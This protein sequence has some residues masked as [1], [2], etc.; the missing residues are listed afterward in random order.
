MSSGSAHLQSLVRGQQGG[1]IRA[2]WRILVPVLAGFL[3][4]RFAGVAAL[5]FDLSRGEMMLVAFGGTTLVMLGV[6]GISARYLDNRPLHEY[7]YRLSRRWWQNLI[8]GTGF[9][10]L[11]VATT[12][13][14]AHSTDSLRVTSKTLVPD[15]ALV[16][17]LLV[18]FAAFVGVAF[19]EE[20]IYRGSFITNAVEGLT[21]RDISRPVA[22]SVALVASTLSFALIH[23][24]GAVLADA[25]VGLVFVKTALLGGLFGVAYLRTDELAL[26]MGLHLGVNYALMNVFGIGAAETP[27][28]PSLLTVE[29]TATGLW[30]ASR[31]IPLFVAIIAGYAIVLLWTRW[32]NRDRTAQQRNHVTRSRS[33]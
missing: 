29:H 17:W 33:D 24:P 23:L 14:I 19:Y 26:P 31:G 20:F 28:V 3:A 2:V 21:A 6:I 16:G 10:A 32:R 7:G 12:V 15:V 11:I 8:I 25:N 9:G 30:S 13:V 1:R 27:G 22:T 5:T 18:F 4:L